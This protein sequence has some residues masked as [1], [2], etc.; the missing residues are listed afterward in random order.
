[1]LS[2]KHRNSLSNDV[3]RNIRVFAK[4]DA[5][6][7]RDEGH[8]D[9]MSCKVIPRRQWKRQA[10][11]KKAA[12]RM[13][14]GSS[15]VIKAIKMATNRVWAGSGA[16]SFAPLL[17]HGLPRTKSSPPRSKLRLDR[18]NIDDLPTVAH[19]LYNPRTGSSQ[20]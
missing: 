2:L 17:V 4:A 8:S 3:P 5:F 10:L 19:A 9:E 7:H 1:L 20:S 15:A 6:S 11:P 18:R 12:R 16:I 13:D 14:T